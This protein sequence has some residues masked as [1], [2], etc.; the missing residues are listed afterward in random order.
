M[1][2]SNESVCFVSSIIHHSLEQRKYVSKQE[3]MHEE[4]TSNLKDFVVV[5]YALVR[6]QEV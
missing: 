4:A 2:P 5:E 3:H 6:G 1:R